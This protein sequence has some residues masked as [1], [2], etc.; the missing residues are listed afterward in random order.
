MSLEQYAY[1]SQIIGVILI[2]A[3]LVYVSRQLH[4]NTEMLKSQSRHAL[5]T[6]DKAAI[7]AAINERDLFELLAKPEPLSFQD[8]FRFTMLTIMS[9]RDRE[10]EFFQYR[11]GAVDEAAWLS[12]REIARLMLDSERKRRWWKKIGK[13]FFDPEFVA[14]IE[15]INAKAPLDDTFTQFGTWE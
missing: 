9:L 6:N 3:S 13:N 5:L 4:Q 11:A 15:E 2:I 12:Y 1:L 14:M 7:Q 10:Y 8:Q